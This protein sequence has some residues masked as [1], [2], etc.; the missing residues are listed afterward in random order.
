MSSVRHN[1]IVP[2][3]VTAAVIGVFYFRGTKKY[4]PL[5]AI[6]LILLFNIT[7]YQISNTRHT[8]NTSMSN[9]MSAFLLTHMIGSVLYHNGYIDKDVKYQLTKEIPEIQWINK[10]NPFT[11][12][13]YIYSDVEPQVVNAVKNIKL[14]EKIILYF[15]LLR[16]NPL[17]VLRHYLDISSI[18]W[19]VFHGADV[20]Y[21]TSRYCFGITNSVEFKQHDSAVK[22]AASNIL[23]ASSSLS[24]FDSIF[25]KTGIYII[26]FLFLLYLSW[27]KKIFRIN[28]IL[29]PVIINLILLIFIT[30]AQDYR[31]TYQ[32]YLIFPFIFLFYLYITANYNKL[33]RVSGEGD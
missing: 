1:G 19:Q 33:P 28:I 18:N 27:I 21:Y 25:W 17:T 2:A 4:I 30:P 15:G 24:I 13:N 10:Y 26:I 22:K 8:S 16:N 5:S 23:S 3:V 7:T 31:Y 12:D 9:T 32:I 14:K 6:I 11:F 20:K 29:L